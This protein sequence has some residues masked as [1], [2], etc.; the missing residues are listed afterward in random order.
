MGSFNKNKKNTN[1][2]TWAAAEAL[3]FIKNSPE[4]L[5]ALSLILIIIKKDKILSDIELEA[6]GFDTNEQSFLLDI[7]S[8]TENDLEKKEK[9]FIN[10]NLRLVNKEIC[11]VFLK[12]KI[13]EYESK[14]RELTSRLAKYAYDNKIDNLE[15]AYRLMVNDSNVELDN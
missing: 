14:K 11:D 9:L 4:P 13:F 12:N 3:R 5:F 2:N 1:D 15:S 8:N 6:I 10:A 7:F